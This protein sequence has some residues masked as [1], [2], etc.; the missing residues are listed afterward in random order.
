MIF[1]MSKEGRQI[2]NASQLRPTISVRMY[3]DQFAMR[4]S[5]QK[6]LIGIPGKN[7]EAFESIL[8]TNRSTMLDDP[9]IRLHGFV[10]AYRYMTEQFVTHDFSRT[11][12]LKLAVLISRNDVEVIRR[13]GDKCKHL[14]HFTISYLAAA[15]DNEGSEVLEA[16]R[17]ETRMDEAVVASP[18]LTLPELRPTGAQERLAQLAEDR[19]IDDALRGR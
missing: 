12:L 8:S 1:F 2:L 16:I 15:V 9:N 18:K 13:L 4:W 14:R 11:D 19:K 5:L 10:D 6:S 7:A 17:K 3:M